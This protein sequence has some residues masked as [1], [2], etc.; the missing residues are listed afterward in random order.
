LSI[1]YAV[2]DS[3]NMAD[4]PMALETL[5]INIPAQF[6]MDERNAA[7]GPPIIDCRKTIA[8]PWPG[9]ITNKVVARMK[10][11]RFSKIATIRPY[12]VLALFPQLPND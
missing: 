5:Q 11:G 9:I 2:S 12:V 8:T 10:E 3:V 6:P 4:S 7:F 1:K